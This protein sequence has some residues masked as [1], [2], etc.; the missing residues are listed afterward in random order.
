MALASATDCLYLDGVENYN[1]RTFRNK[2]LLVQEGNSLAISVPLCKGKHSGQS[3]RDVQISYAADWQTKH[4]RSLRAF[5]GK[6]PYFVHYFPEIEKIYAIQ[7]DA[8]FSWD[9]LIIEWLCDE[10]GLKTVFSVQDDFIKSSDENYLV[11]RDQF[12]YKGDFTLA[13]EWV[14]ERMH[15]LDGL[16]H[17]PFVPSPR[18]S[19]LY[20]LFHLGPET[21][22]YLRHLAENLI[23]HF[24]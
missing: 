18:H 5:F 1:K 11:V 13:E 20:L 17:L 9:R 22:L 3:I 4:L 21:R 7:P 15:S 12:R 10:I 19:V 6:T 8:L 24:E 2:A 16:T 23:G 14:L